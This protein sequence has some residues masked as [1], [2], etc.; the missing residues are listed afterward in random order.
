[1]EVWVPCSEN[2]CLGALKPTEEASLQEKFPELFVSP[3]ST[4]E[5]LCGLSG[6]DLEG[7]ASS[8]CVRPGLPV[9]KPI[10]AILPGWGVYPLQLA[11]LGMGPELV[12]QTER[13][14]I[15]KMLYLFLN[16]KLVQ[17]EET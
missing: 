1:M 11:L 6:A 7:P 15:S 14:L 3:S 2:L 8:E 4:L 5:Y 17:V 16:H 12:I 9:R 13:M 10:V